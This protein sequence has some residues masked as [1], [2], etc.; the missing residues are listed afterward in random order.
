M[1][2]QEMVIEMSVASLIAHGAPEQDA[3]RCMSGV[4]A[5]DAEEQIRCDTYLSMKAALAAVYPRIRQQVISE[6]M[7]ACEGEK[8]TSEVHMTK[9]RLEYNFG[10]DDCLSAIRNL[11]DKTDEA[12]NG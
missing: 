4:C 3:R 7:E 8:Y 2:T 1:I 11:K 9:E 6:C 12:R 10:C 5:S